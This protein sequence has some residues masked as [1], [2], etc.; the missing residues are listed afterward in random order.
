[1]ITADASGLTA[2]FDKEHKHGAELTR[3]AL[4]HARRNG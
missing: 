4:L 1:L 2:L 3:S